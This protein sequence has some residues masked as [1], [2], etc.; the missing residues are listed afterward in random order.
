MKGLIL[1]SLPFLFLMMGCGSEQQDE[2]QSFSLDNLTPSEAQEA[3]TIQD[4]S[5][6]DIETIEQVVTTFV[7]TVYVE[8]EE[9]YQERKEEARSIMNENMHHYLF[10]SEENAQD[11]LRAYVSDLAVYVEVDSIRNEHT[12]Q[13]VLTTFTHTI[14]YLSNGQRNQSQTF[15]QVEVSREDGEWIITNFHDAA[16]ESPENPSWTD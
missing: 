3:S 4:S 15:L 1:L 14:E 10:P 5:S 13:Q 11:D 16:N 6:S 12:N 7:N 9:G 2:E 8:N